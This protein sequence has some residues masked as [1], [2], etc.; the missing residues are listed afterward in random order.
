MTEPVPDLPATPGLT[1][2]LNIALAQF[3]AQ[4]PVLERDRHVDVETKDPSKAYGYDYA[5]LA[6]VTQTAMPLMGKLGLSFA[7]FPGRGTDGKMA[8]R[9]SLRHSSGEEVSGEFPLSG[10]GGIQILGG[11]ITY[12]RRYCLMAVLGLASEEDD[13]AAAAQAEDEGKRGTAQR[14]AQPARRAAAAPRSDAATA[15]RTERPPPPPIPSRGEDVSDRASNPQ[16]QKI[17]ILSGEVGVTDRDERLT[18]LS[19]LVGRPLSSGKDLSKSE[20]HELIE[21]LGPI[22]GSPK[23]MEA[24]RDAIANKTNAKPEDGEPS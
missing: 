8:L 2:H 6:N 11:R 20:A 3:Q 17:A 19:A 10:E 18:V 5:T 15:Q 14:R 22:A 1:P 23:P 16:L 7:A 24:L 21:T 4:M 12:A 13:D 9:Y